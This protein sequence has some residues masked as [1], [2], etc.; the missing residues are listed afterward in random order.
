M[1]NTGGPGEPS[2]WFKKTLLGSRH[3]GVWLD[4]L[5]VLKERNDRV[6]VREIQKVPEVVMLELAR[7]ELR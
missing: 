2:A 7:R 5:P 6:V 3:L 4:L 1:G